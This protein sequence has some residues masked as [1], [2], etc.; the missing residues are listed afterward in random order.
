MC[1]VVVVVVCHLAQQD[2]YL[3][4]FFLFYGDLAHLINRNVCAFSVSLRHSPTTL[5]HIPVCVV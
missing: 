2:E 1:D 5:R 4:I 3:M